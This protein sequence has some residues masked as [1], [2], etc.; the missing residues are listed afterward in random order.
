MRLMKPA[1]S[2]SIW[3]KRTDGSARI[4]TLAAAQ[5]QREENERLAA[6][7]RQR[8]ENERLAAEQRQR[9]ENERL[10]AEQRQREKTNA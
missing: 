3:K 1:L 8:E 10:A 2:C 9:E 7:Q 4:T 5:R 6:E